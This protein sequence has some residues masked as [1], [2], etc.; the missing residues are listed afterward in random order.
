MSFFVRRTLSKCEIL[1]NLMWLIEDNFPQKLPQRTI[2]PLKPHTTP[3][4]YSPCKTSTKA[5]TPGQIEILLKF[6]FTLKP[7]KIEI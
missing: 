6:T 2:D 1:N 7:H 3:K 5:S 4:G